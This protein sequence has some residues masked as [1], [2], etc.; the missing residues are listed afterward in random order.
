MASNWNRPSQSEQKEK[1][2]GSKSNFGMLLAL[3]V[4]AVIGVVACILFSGGRDEKLA[5]SENARRSRIKDVAP[6]QSAKPREE[7]PIAV[8]NTMTSAATSQVRLVKAVVTN[9]AS[10]K[11]RRELIDGEWRVRESKAVFQHPME[12]ALYAMTVPNGMALPPKSIFR[13][14][15]DEQILEMLK[16]PVEYKDGDSEI[17][18]ER[19]DRMQKMKDKM[20]SLYN[21]GYGLNDIITELDKN[22]RLENFEM[23]DARN[24]LNDV[25]KSGDDDKVREYIKTKNAEL[26]EKGLGGLKVPPRFR[27]KPEAVQLPAETDVLQT[28]GGN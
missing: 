12:R 7:K 18:R 19:K 23:A 13:R 1:G 8:T 10:F 4:L 14:Y 27:E 15:T 26:N 28:E 24:G 25:M 22:S 2:K 3:I 16:K 20:L 5:S 21:L 9:V 6:A 17:V 11:R